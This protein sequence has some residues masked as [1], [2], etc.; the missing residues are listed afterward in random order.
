MRLLDL[1][2][3]QGKRAAA[4]PL[5]SDPAPCPGSEFKLT[6]RSKNAD[7]RNEMS[8]AERRGTER[9]LV[10]IPIRVIAFGAHGSGFTE[11][12]YT[13]EVN[14][15]GA[16]IALKHRVGADDALRIVNLQNYTEADF[17]VVGATRLA[18]EGASE[19]GVECLDEGRNIWGIDFPPP[20]PDQDSQAGALL[21]CQGC[22]KQALSVLTM[23]E[24]TILDSTGVLQKPCDVCA[25]H[26]PWAYASMPGGGPAD[27]PP[28]QPAPSPPPAAKRDEGIERRVHRRVAL[29]LSVLVRN[30]QGQ[31]HVVKTENISKGGL[32]VCLPMMLDVGEIVTVVCPYMAGGQNLEQKAEVRRRA[33]FLAGEKWLYGMK[34]L[35]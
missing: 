12:S 11:D 9:L 1:P 20:L 17:R 4:P 35:R 14:R 18:A 25:Q 34:Y 7:I 16:R 29:K 5:G 27:P 3:G 10:T 15:A 28:S 23:M 22:G 32:A 30:H 8:G 2:V 19:W 33:D 24:V 6:E 21:K 31:E 13:V 26:S